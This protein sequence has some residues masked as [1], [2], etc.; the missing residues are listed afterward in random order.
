MTQSTTTHLIHTATRENERLV[1]VNLFADQGRPL[2]TGD[3]WLVIKIGVLKPGEVGRAHRRIDYLGSWDS[4]KN[5]LREQ[6]RVKI[7]GQQDLFY[8]FA[9]GDI[10]VAEL[11]VNGQPTSEAG[12]SVEAEFQRLG[13]VSTEQD[14][15]PV[16]PTMPSPRRPGEPLFS[17]GRHIEDPNTRAAAESLESALN[18]SGVTTFYISYSFSPSLGFVDA[19]YAT[20]DNSS[21]VN[22]TSSTFE[23]LEE[24]T[25]TPPDA[26]S[27]LAILMG[28]GSFLG[29][30]Q[31]ILRIRQDTDGNNGPTA[32]V[33]R[34]GSGDIAHA[35]VYY[36][37]V[38]TDGE[39]KTFKLQG[40]GS[41]SGYWGYTKHLQGFLMPLEQATR[42]LT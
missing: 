31:G 41:T 38:I 30:A 28:Q 32:T 3:N 9:V 40:S 42:R 35:A 17:L 1:A 11:T 2:S 33:G 7:T 27:W 29:G 24:I 20:D 21:T 14:R 5:I 4:R 34:S 36:M 15:R 37:E 25:L 23:D 13:S 22:A 18:E 26:R 16:E 19:P 12:M 10:L 39:A 8:P 6:Q